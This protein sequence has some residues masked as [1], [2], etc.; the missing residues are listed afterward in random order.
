MTRFTK[1]A[2]HELHLRCNAMGAVVD[3]VWNRGLTLDSGKHLNFFGV[4]ARCAGGRSEH[5]AV[6]DGGFFWSAIPDVPGERG[7]GR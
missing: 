4:W 3:A 5:M 2:S 6:G 1:F 7:E